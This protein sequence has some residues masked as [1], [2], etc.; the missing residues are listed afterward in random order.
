M[1]ALIIAGILAGIFLG[2][3]GDDFK[4][5]KE[6]LTIDFS[7]SEVYD[8]DGNLICTL[9]GNEKRKIVSLEDMPEYLPKAYVAIEDERFYEHTGVDIKRTAAATA[10]YILN[11]GSSSFGGST[12]TQQLVK[13]I[14][15]DKEDSALRKVKEMARA[16]QIEKEISKD[17]ILELYLDIIFVGGNNIN[18]V[19]LNFLNDGVYIFIF[20]KAEFRMILISIFNYS[21]INH[22]FFLKVIIAFKAQLAA[23][24]HDG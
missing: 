16:I 3:F 14:T 12:I 2:F 7:N 17:N 10:T 5:T 24:P 13:N 18:G 4:M 1:A 23:K 8:A 20:V 19:A 9:N 21:Q 11:R 6:D 15:D 22:Q